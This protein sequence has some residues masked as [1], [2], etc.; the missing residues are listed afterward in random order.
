MTTYKEGPI[1]G[2]FLYKQLDAV[3]T[4]GWR[5]PFTLSEVLETVDWHFKGGSTEQAA[6]NGRIPVVTS[7]SVYPDGVSKDFAKTLRNMTAVSEALG[8]PVDTSVI[9]DLRRNRVNCQSLLDVLKKRLRNCSGARH[10][11]KRDLVTFIAATHKARTLEG[12]MR[13]ETG[14][15]AV[16]QL[17]PIIWDTKKVMGQKGYCS[18]SDAGDMM[19]YIKEVMV[20]SSFA[21]NLD[22]QTV[23]DTCNRVRANMEGSRVQVLM[24]AHRGI[25]CMLRAASSRDARDLADKMAMRMTDVEEEPGV[26]EEIGEKVWRN[27]SD[28]VAGFKTVGINGHLILQVSTSE[29]YVLA[30]SDTKRLLQTLIGAASSTMAIAAQVCSGTMLERSYASRVMEAADDAITDM[31]KFCK[32]VGVGMEVTVCKSLKKAFAT[33]LSILSGPMSQE[34][35]VVLMKEA[36]V[37]AGKNSTVVHSWVERCKGLPVTHAFNIGKLYKILPSPDISPAAAFLDRIMAIKNP[38]VVDDDMIVEFRTELRDQILAARIR[39]GGPKIPLRPRVVRPRW[40]GAY[41]RGEYDEVPIV[42]IHAYLAYEKT[43]TMPSR[44]KMDP[45]IWKDSGLGADTVELGV[46]GDVPRRHK[47]MLTRMVFD[48]NCPMPGSEETAHTGKLSI[49]SDIKPESHKD[50]ARCIF[51]A[52]MNIRHAKSRM[53]LAV[54]E[55]ASHHSSFMIGAGPE[56]IQKMIRA[57]TATCRN[58]DTMTFYDSFDVAGWSG[59]MPQVVQEI[60][61]EIWATLYETTQFD[62]ASKL[63]QG[64]TVYM[65]TNGYVGTYVNPQAN[66]EGFDGKEMTMINIALL[67]LSVK[68]WRARPEVIAAIGA[69]AANGTAALLLAY[70]DDGMARLDLPIAHYYVLAD[71]FKDCRLMTFGGC[72]FKIEPAKCFPSDCFFVFLNE[73]YLAGRHVVHGVRAAARICSEPIEP[74]E[75]LVHVI[76]K[77]STGCRGAVMSGLDTVTAMYI[78]AFHSYLHIKEWIPKV[79]GSVAAV[80]ALTPRAWGGL[81]MPSPMQLQT[82][83]SGSSVAEGITMIQKWAHHNRAVKKVYIRLCRSEFSERSAAGILTAPI[84]AH[85]PEGFIRDGRVSKAV[86]EAFRTIQGNMGLSQLASLYMGYSDRVDFERYAGMVVP[87]VVGVSI[88]VSVLDDL[89]SAHPESVFNA[90]CARIER[91]G[92]LRCVVGAK[93]MAKIV[94]DQRNEARSSYAIFTGKIVG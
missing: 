87:S 85:I 62:N 44:D 89:Y 38:N 32:S 53:E 61:H 2:E 15:S 39:M 40:Y 34:E 33:Y 83:A 13:V 18:M 54:E 68:R 57:A 75:S 63:M 70:I 7:N 93:T 22:P 31:F 42:E 59:N 6:S 60:S 10:S 41:L 19:A 29:C 45:S 12:N 43:L 74:Y 16:Y 23:M 4:L 48:N 51:S 80:W 21:S 78:L 27:A 77:T 67:S 28:T 55:V 50:P 64:V 26:L 81:G 1:Y 86:K 71:S 52:N 73:P 11:A 90:F 84:S 65:N 24:E 49:K 88:Q 76:D 36:V 46:S 14:L 91:S 5:S 58:A 9:A 3:T 37:S 94:A 20:G 69:R 30:P 47:N 8:A 17:L 72:G 92:T 82:T 79:S 35:T 56:K 66:L 25:T